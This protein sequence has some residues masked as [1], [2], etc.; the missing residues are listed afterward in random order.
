MSSWR[1]SRVELESKGC[2]YSIYTDRLP[3]RCGRT[4]SQ[5]NE[6]KPTKTNALTMRSLISLPVEL[7]RIILTFVEPG[8]IPSLYSSCKQFQILV[9]DRLEEHK[10]LTDLHRN[11]HNGRRL[12]IMADDSSGRIEEPTE[13][14][15]CLRRLILDI[16]ENPRFAWYIREPLWERIE[17]LRDKRDN[18]TGQSL[19]HR[20]IDSSRYISAGERKD[21]M[22][23]AERA[24]MGILLALLLSQLPRLRTV[25]IQSQPDDPTLTYVTRMINRV[26]ANS[27][28]GY[29]E[30]PLSG[31][32]VVHVRHA[33]WTQTWEETYMG[34]TVRLLIALATLPN[35]KYLYLHNYSSHS[36]IG[37]TRNY[38]DWIGKL[39]KL[40]PYC[41]LFLG[42]STLKS[43]EIITGCISASVLSVILKNCAALE[44]FKYRIEDTGEVFGSS[45]AKEDPLPDFHISSIC[46]TLLSYTH[47]SLKSLHMEIDGLNRIR[48]P[49]QPR[50]LQR[51]TF[52]QSV[53]LDSELFGEKPD[54]WP[55]PADI[56][57][58]SIKE[59]CILA[60]QFSSDAD[61]PMIQTT[62]QNFRPQPFPHLHTLA[63]W[64]ISQVTDD[65][66]ST[67][68]MIPV[69]R[70]I[71]T[72]AGIP[73][74]KI[75]E[76]H[77]DSNVFVDRCIRPTYTQPTYHDGRFSWEIYGLPG[78]D[79]AGHFIMGVHH[80]E[81]STAGPFQPREKVFD[82]VRVRKSW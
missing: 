72:D 81:G 34:K 36:L 75:L 10:H 12:A 55:L 45:S 58:A 30:E 44:H 18:D 37:E 54:N 11:R 80:S 4:F 15:P 47:L 61:N 79:T 2:F 20:L 33:P 51:F 74:S 29:L 71:L 19:V 53:A 57:P 5:L 41:P 66:T 32:E 64:S 25:N 73:E 63:I 38:S 3:L 62:L 1:W 16:E 21:W 9:G 6:D 48:F 77:V 60:A 59:I 27:H 52:L 40:D 31:L 50:D 56:L 70:S 39:D 28:Q 82:G 69:F 26:A 17:D 78:G 49:F 43:L 14:W 46:A 65:P 8:D 22:Q 67:S 42:P 24:E 68:H 7:Q 35:L 23:A 13:S 76:Y